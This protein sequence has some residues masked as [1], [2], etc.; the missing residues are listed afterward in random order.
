MALAC[1]VGSVVAAGMVAVL[2]AVVFASGS[3]GAG[4]GGV[5][6]CLLFCMVFLQ[7][8]VIAGDGVSI[9][10]MQGWICWLQWGLAKG[11][12]GLDGKHCGSA[13]VVL[14]MVGVVAVRP[15]CC[16]VG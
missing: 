7:I 8:S 10:F 16:R 4:F 11:G 1:D 6:R 2:V 9:S 5:V 12:F 3:V 14:T 15:A 13:M